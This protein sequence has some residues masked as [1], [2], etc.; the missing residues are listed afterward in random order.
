[1]NARELIDLYFMDARS[2]VIDLAAFLDRIERSGGA[3][4]YRLDALL[5]ALE[6]LRAGGDDRARRVLECLSDPTREPI[7]RA[8][9]KGA[10]GA[11]RGPEES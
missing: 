1:M 4:D 9:G 10:A 8:D 5:R 2:K 11:W 3:D 6:E 7:A